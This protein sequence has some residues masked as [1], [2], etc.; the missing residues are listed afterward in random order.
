MLTGSVGYYIVHEVYSI[1]IC[2]ALTYVLQIWIY[3][4]L[5]LL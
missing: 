1:I 5:F 2:L 4:I 3:V